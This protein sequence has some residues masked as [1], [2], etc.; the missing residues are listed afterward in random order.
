MDENNEKLIMVSP[1]NQTR[2]QIITEGK[3]KKGGTNPVSNNPPPKVAPQG[4]PGA[5]PAHAK[6]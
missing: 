1:K 4:K 5:R 6:K 2:G 3:I